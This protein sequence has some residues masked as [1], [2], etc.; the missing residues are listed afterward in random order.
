[1]PAHNWSIVEDGIFH[2]FHMTWIGQIQSALND[3]LLPK[4]YYALA[5]QHFGYGIADVL[6]L[7]TGDESDNSAGNGDGP[8]NSGSSGVAV[9]EVSPKTKWHHTLKGT[10]RALQRSIAIRHV[11]G[12]RLIAL[13][14]IV[15]PANKDRATHVADF[16]VKAADS[17]KHGI[18]VLL[19]DL[20]LPGRFD[21]QGMHG[22]ICQRFEDSD[23]ADLP[24]DEPLT[25]AAFS[26]GEKIEV[27]VEHLKFGQPLI[28][29]PLFLQPDRYVNVPLEETYLAAFKGMPAFWREKLEEKS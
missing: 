18:H 13:L 17:V 20:I 2:A 25:L 27:Y 5:E 4:S 11:T 23:K 10:S 26:A 6:T 14:E 12:H 29:M 22:E 9:A 8:Y 1:M 16:A 7:H 21:P 24:P 28:D 15:S 19:V 3:R